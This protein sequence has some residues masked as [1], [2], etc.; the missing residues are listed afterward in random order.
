MAANSRSTSAVQDIGLLLIRLLF[1]VI[2]LYYGSQKLFGAF[3]GPGIAGF[4]GFLKMLHVPMP[5]LSAI[6]SACAEFFGGLF[7]LIGTGMRLLAIPLAV[8]MIVA[9]NTKMHF[10]MAANAVVA[11][12][13][14][15]HANHPGQLQNVFFAAQF[16]FSLLI[17]TIAMLLIGPGNIT[18]G[19]L[20]LKKKAAAPAA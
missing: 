3:G 13:I 5:H 9:T 6:L 18:L 4:T 15:E 8:N 7:F 12:K 16:P 14:A 1:A 2:F 20:L 11:H 17:V 19:K 10:A